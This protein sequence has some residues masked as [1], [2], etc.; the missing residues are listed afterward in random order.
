MIK[1]K[2]LGLG[3][4]GNKAV[5]LA[6]E[7]EI[8]KEEDVILVNSTDDDIPDTYDGK[9]VIL[10]GNTG[11]TGKNRKT[12]KAQAEAVINKQLVNFED[13]LGLVNG[14]EKYERVVMV[15]ST[16][17]GSGSGSTPVFAKYIINTLHVPVTIMAFVGKSTDIAGSRNTIEFLQEIS[18]IE[19][20]NYTLI[21]NSDF[22]K[23]KMDYDDSRIEIDAN[24]HLCLLLSIFLGNTITP[25]ASQNMDKRDQQTVTRTP[26]YMVIA[27]HHFD[28][29]V[30]N[31]QTVIDSLKL[32]LDDSLKCP[33]PSSSGFVNFGLIAT[34]ET[35]DEL[36][37]LNAAEAVVKEKFGNWMRYY[38]HRQV[39]DRTTIDIIMSGMKAPTEWF[40][41][42][43][44]SYRA[45]S[46]QVD[47]TASTI[48]A[49]QKFALD[50]D[51]ALADPF[52]SDSF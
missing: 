17:G 19:N 46:A 52:V 44:N 29:R 2:V 47:R 37:Y 26:G 12:S 38:T 10:P 27:S 5:A 40:E 15:C 51:S 16:S 13:E 22:M 9:V 6:I 23:S 49:G 35:N 43:Y 14:K 45:A 8:I 28:E 42:M 32:T 50:D 25:G 39:G 4:A 1:T 11:G 33:D 31:E 7:S 3:A 34:A 20:L 18:E 21:M 36:K 24:K 48:T 41:S 30:K